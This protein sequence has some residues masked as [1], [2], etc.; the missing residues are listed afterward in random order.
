MRSRI[1]DTLPREGVLELCGDATHTLGQ[2]RT[3]VIEN[4]SMD[5][6]VLR[7]PADDIGTTGRV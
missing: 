5:R 7:V 3:W 1:W 4:N 6:F 2:L